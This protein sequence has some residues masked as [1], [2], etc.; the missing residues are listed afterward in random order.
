MKTK[1]KTKRMGALGAML[2]GCA[3]EIMPLVSF[4]AT[5][6][7]PTIIPEPDTILLIGLG[8]AAVWVARRI[9]K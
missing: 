3:M 6:P 9:K 4:A 5:Q 2:A 1:P 8:A 7:P